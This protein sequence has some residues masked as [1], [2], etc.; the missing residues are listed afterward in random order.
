MTDDEINFRV[1][2]I[3]GWLVPVDFPIKRPAPF[4]SEWGLCGPLIEKNE[5][6]LVI[7]IN[8]EYC[9]Y[10]GNNERCDPSLRRAICLAAIAKHQGGD[11]E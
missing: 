7:R 10:S 1:M 9:V 11:A 4:T 3:E 2:E 8:G 5:I 6:R